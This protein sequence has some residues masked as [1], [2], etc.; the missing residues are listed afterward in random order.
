MLQKENRLTELHDVST[1]LIV[2]SLS[3]IEYDRCTRK[4]IRIRKKQI[5]SKLTLNQNTILKKSGC[6]YHLNMHTAIN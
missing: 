4:K 3:S 6:A 5:Y 2:V 1:A